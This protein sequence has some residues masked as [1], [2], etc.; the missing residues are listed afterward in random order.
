MLPLL[1]S[2]CK[3]KNLTFRIPM[4]EVLDYCVL[5]YSF[6]L[7]QW[8]TSISTIP[9]KSADDQALFDHLM[10]ISGPD[11]FAETSRYLFLSYKPP[12]S[13]VIMAMT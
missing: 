4:P 3:N 1:E 5:E 13:S 2:Y 10:E 6:A 9:S 7:W 12:V 11:Y 8:G